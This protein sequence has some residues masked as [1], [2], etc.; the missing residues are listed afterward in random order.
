GDDFT[1]WAGYGEHLVKLGPDLAVEESDHPG[2]LTTPDDLDFVGSPIVLDRA[3]CG[4]LVVGA[5][6]DDEVYAWH[7]DDVGSGP[8]WELQLEPFDG[9][10][11]LLSPLAWAP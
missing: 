2:D 7:A 1:E 11:P 10:D 4:E 8:L 5:D 9:G 3:S 6:K